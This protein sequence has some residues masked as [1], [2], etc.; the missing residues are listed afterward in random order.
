MLLDEFLSCVNCVFC[1]ILQVI[2]PHH[3]KLSE[4]EVSKSLKKSLNFTFKLFI[5]LLNSH[6][7]RSELLLFI[8]RVN[9]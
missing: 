4:K 9:D 3:S 5:I 2:Y 8:V 1:C 6:F 7:K